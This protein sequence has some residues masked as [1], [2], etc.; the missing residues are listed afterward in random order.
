MDNSPKTEA[1]DGVGVAADSGHRDSGS[2]G[3]DE[4]TRRPRADWQLPTS[5]QRCPSCLDFWV[6]T[7]VCVYDEGW[8]L[9]WTCGDEDKSCWG[10][11]TAPLDDLEWPFE[12]YDEPTSREELEALGFIVIVV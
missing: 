7:A 3:G 2:G 10:L 12:D 9:E 11:A 6:P 1:N 5:D 8:S 4:A